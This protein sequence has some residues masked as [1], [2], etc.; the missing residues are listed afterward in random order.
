[1]SVLEAGSGP[2]PCSRLSADARAP[3]A[4]D[5]SRPLAAERRAGPRGDRA[6]ADEGRDAGARLRLR[7][8]VV[9]GGLVAQAEHLPYLSQFR[10]RF[11]LAAL[12]EPSESVR[13]ALAARYGIAAT[14]ADYR[15]LLDAGGIDAVVICSPAGTHAEVALASLDAALHVFVE[16]P[17]CI[18]L[19]DADAIVAARDRSAKVVQVGY[20]KRF[21]PAY[22]RLLDELP[23]S[24]AGLRYVSVVVND[25][26]FRPFFTQGEIVRGEVPREVIEATRRAE[27]EQVEAAVGNGSPEVV[28]AFSEAFLGSLVHDVNLVH[29]VL[30]RLG[31]PLPAEVVGGAWWAGG[32]AVSGSVRLANGSR[33]DS[34]WIQLLDVW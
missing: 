22:E 11:E 7:I 5:P 2:D 31:E 4:R 14:H 23:S 12:V 20:M 19:A 15:A 30:E 1:L 3:R 29:G 28:T 6:R 8:G 9:G 24:A 34:A 21:D 25:P 16:K 27:S 33:W 18:P 13:E 17:M 32:S 26:E 10:D